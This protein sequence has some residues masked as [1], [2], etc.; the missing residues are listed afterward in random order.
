MECQGMQAVEGAAL[1][2]LWPIVELAA[3]LEGK[4]RHHF[5]SGLPTDRPDRPE[6]L[7]GTALR[8][9]QE[10]GLALAPLQPA[11]HNQDGAHSY[12]IQVLHS[13]PHSCM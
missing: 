11:L 13:L 5:A 7:F 4:L 1:P 10:G 8:A 12:N 6:W 3:P 2:L 9:A